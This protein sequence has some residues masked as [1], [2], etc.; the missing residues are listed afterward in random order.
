MNQGAAIRRLLTFC[1][2]LV[3]SQFVHEPLFAFQQAGA[4]AGAAQWNFSDDEA[5]PTWTDDLKDQAADLALFAAFAV[6][7]LVSFFRKS[8]LLKWI[9]MGTAVIYLGFVRSQQI[10]RAHV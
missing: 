2:I 3:F 8:E 5:V 1:L 9:T 4:P 10:G 6:L 7:A